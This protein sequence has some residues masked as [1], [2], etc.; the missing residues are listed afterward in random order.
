MSF[1]DRC[2]STFDDALK[3]FV[4]GKQE[5]DRPSPA[6]SVADNVAGLSSAQRKHIAGL[7]RVNHCGEVCA[8]AL[9]K[10]QALTAK[11]DFVRGAMHAAAMEEEDHLAWCE[12]RID[13]LGSRTSYL[14]PLWFGLSFSIGA[15]AGA[16]G[17]KVSLGFV[18]ATEQQVCEHLE[19]HYRQLPD[20]DLAT[21]AIL[22]QMIIDEG[23]HAEQALDA[24]G[25]PFPGVV[26]NTMMFV[27]KAMTKVSYRI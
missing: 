4:G 7:M 18:A 14:N 13:Q 15:L 21:R 27:S 23:E 12:Q 20:N 8:Q 16:I 25:Q 3:T 6:D 5:Y 17:D 22:E 19:E 1:V 11:S 26:R 10:G 9:Y 24:G 2:V